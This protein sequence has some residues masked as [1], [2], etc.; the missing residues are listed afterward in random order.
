MHHVTYV[1]NKP[2]MLSMLI[3][4]C[5]E[6]F[7]LC[8]D[9]W[10][11]NTEHEYTQYN[12]NNFSATRHNYTWC[13]VSLMLSVANKLTCRMSLLWGLESFLLIADKKTLHA[14]RANIIMLRFVF[15]VC[16][17]FFF[18]RWVL[19]LNKLCWVGEYA[20]HK[21]RIAYK[22]FGPSFQV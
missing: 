5:W 1:D 20:I 19:L 2:Y 17:Y 11:N 22:L 14:K 3:L 6:L 16:R 18:L 7:R 13:I 15:A 10:Q 21:W 9:I 12:D 4:L 8:Y